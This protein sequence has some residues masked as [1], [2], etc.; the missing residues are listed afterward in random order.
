MKLVSKTDNY[1]I[2]DCFEF[3]D[4]I[5]DFGVIFL[6]DNTYPDGK[7]YHLFPVKL[8]TTKTGMDK[9]RYGKVYLSNFV[10]F[11][12]MNGKTEGFMVYYFMQQKDFNKINSLFSYVGSIPIKHKYKNT[13]GGTIAETYDDF[14][15][16]LNRWKQ[17]FGQNAH[18]ISVF[19]IYE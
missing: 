1:K 12:N 11:T 6:E 10:D 4:K 14:R 2:G 8:D 5:N 7:Q 9:F 17:M 18:L 19:D 16:Q 15:F 13:T 3:K